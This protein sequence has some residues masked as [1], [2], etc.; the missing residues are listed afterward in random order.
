[1]E[2]QLRLTYEER[3]FLIGKLTATIDR[4]KLHI[5]EIGAKEVIEVSTTIRQRLLD[6]GQ[7][8]TPK[9]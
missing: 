4:A 6:Y 8:I 7:E 2:I 9:N 3:L 1:M 5:E